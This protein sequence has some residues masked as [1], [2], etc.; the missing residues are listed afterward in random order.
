MINNQLDDIEGSM[1]LTRRLVT[2]FHSFIN[3]SCE[4]NVE[5]GDFS[6]T[7]P[8]HTAV[9]KSSAL[10]TVA[11]KDVEA[12]QRK[13]YTYYTSMKRLCVKTALREV[14]R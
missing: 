8:P 10:A 3:H 13:R 14:P 6:T 11:K 12:E 7:Y 2:P 5:N 4:P 9:M 1:A